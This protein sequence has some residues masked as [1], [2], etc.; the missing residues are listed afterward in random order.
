[1][2]DVRFLN[3]IENA[4]KIHGYKYDYIEYKNMRTPIKLSFGG[5]VYTQNP[6]KHLLGRCPEKNTPKLTVGEFFKKSKEIWGDRFDYSKTNYD[7]ALRDIIIIDKLTGIEYKQRANSHLNGVDPFKKITTED[8]ILM[9]KEKYGDDYDYSLTKYCDYHKKVKIIFKNS[10]EIFEQTP[11]GHL[12]GCRPEL[13]KRM[14]CGGFIKLSNIVHD[15][16]YKYDKSIYVNA[17]TKVVITCQVHGDFLQTPNSHLGGAGCPSCQESKGEKIISKFL[18]KNDIL[19]YRQHKFDEC[20]NIYQLPFDFYIPSLR[21]AIEF[22]G[23]QHFQPIEY[24]GG[25]KAYESL[26]TNDK[27][28]SDYCEDN[29]I[30]LIRI[31]Y[32]EIDKI[33]K[34]LRENIR[35]IK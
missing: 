8:F 3:F 30:N 22:D 24:F 29:Y 1:M 34:I 20:K 7:G 33:E 2:K 27:I 21:T 11:S 5:V 16:K 32:D 17:K 18:N 4:R 26:K 10:G 15:D 28:K 13:I 31:R 35:N 25:L 6:Q 14:D 12:S 19:Y 23:L 9:S